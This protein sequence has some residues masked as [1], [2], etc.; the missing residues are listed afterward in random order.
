MRGRI[1]NICRGWG[2]DLSPF[3]ARSRYIPESERDCNYVHEYIPTVMGGKCPDYE[4]KK[5]QRWGHGSTDADD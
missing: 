3:C 5:P 2:C 1:I 4:S